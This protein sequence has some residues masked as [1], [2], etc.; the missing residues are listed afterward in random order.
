MSKQQADIKR[1][2]ANTGLSR[3][4]IL[5][6]KDAFLVYDKDGDGTM[7]LKELGAVMRSLGNN[8]TEQELQD[9]INETDEVGSVSIRLKL[10]F[11]ADS[12]LKDGSGTM[13]F[14][15]FCTLMARVR[16]N[17]DTVEEIREAFKCF[18]KNASGSIPEQELRQTFKYIMGLEYLNLK[19]TEE[20]CD[21]MIAFIDKDGSGDVDFKKFM[22]IMTPVDS[23]H[24]EG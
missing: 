15:E 10:L 12:F 20:E 23:I 1:A 9:M 4:E 18:T 21:E 19:L 3:E 5:E 14:L 2:V 6:F 24:K 8:P 22:A 16:N 11:S 13:D 7:S 17:V